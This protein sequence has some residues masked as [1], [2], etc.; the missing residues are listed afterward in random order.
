MVFPEEEE[1]NLILAYMEGAKG[2]GITSVNDVMPYFHGN[3]GTPAVYSAMDQAGQLTVRI[4]A[5]P[6]LLGDL[7]EITGWRTRYNSEKLRFDMVKSFLD[8]VSTT[9]TAL[10]LEDYAD[11]PG[12]RGLPLFDLTRIERAT[13]EAHRRELSVKL[14][15]CGD[16]SLRKALD[17]YEAAQKQYGKNRCRH[18][19]EHCEIVN[20]ADIPRFGALG[21][22]PSVQPEHLALTRTFDENPYPMT[23]GA[24]RTAHTWP[25][26]RMLQSAGV[27]AIGSDC[28][29]VDSNPFLEIG[30]A[31]TRTHDDGQPEGG[32]NP[33]EKLSLA[34][35]LRAFT[36]GSAFGVGRED[37]LG[38]LTPG[39]FADIAI[40]DRDLFS[41]APEDLKNC[42]VW[43][44]IM[45][46]KIVFS[47]PACG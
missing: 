40:S 30:R 35:V 37:E 47:Q 14:H 46:G 9:H 17:F 29:V 21:V 20:E 42:R 24:A 13:P 33:A 27:L 7:D 31:V 3:M 45:D 32:W 6:D 38:T 26:K 18:A 25:F 10:M 11:A 43:M 12:N 8:G 36:W 15:A 2:Y 44:T 4:H 1:K 19:I 23:L 16:A 41:A 39:K 5:A 28:P 22:V 34:E